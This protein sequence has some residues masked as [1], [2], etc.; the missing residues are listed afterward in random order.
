MALT[1]VVIPVGIVYVVFRF[2]RAYERR[3][4]AMARVE[5]LERRLAHLKSEQTVTPPSLPPV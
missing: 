5:A 4:E 3:G 1:W 2:L